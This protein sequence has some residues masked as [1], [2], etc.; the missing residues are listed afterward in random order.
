[1][2]FQ[3]S[4]CGKLLQSYEP[5][6]MTQLIVTAQRLLLDTT[7][8]TLRTWLLLITNLC[9]YGQPLSP[10]ISEVFATTIGIHKINEMAPPDQDKLYGEVSEEFIEKYGDIFPE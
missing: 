9:F 4:L 7:S 2:C 8:D 10:E 5:E 3:L 6:T 1:M